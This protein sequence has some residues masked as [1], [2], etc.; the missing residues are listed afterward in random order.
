MC[1]VVVVITDVLTHQAFQMGL[2]EHD[3]MIEQISSTVAN[4]AFGDAVL[5][6]TSEAGPFGRNAKA[7]HR[8][9]DFLIEVRA[10]IKDQVSGN[11]IIREG[12]AKL[13]HD[14][15][16]GGMLGRTAMENPSPLMGANEEAIDNAEGQRRHGK[17]VH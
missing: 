2:V 12:L 4:P 11:R 17:E 10:A 13:L 14:P 8:T 15:R 3:H 1:P 5:P 6:G 9:N 16:A 7:L